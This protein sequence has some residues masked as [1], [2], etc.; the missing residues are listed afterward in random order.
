M[1]SNTYTPYADRQANLL[2]YEILHL[3]RRPARGDADPN[4]GV[5]AITAAGH[6]PNE[7]VSCHPGMSARRRNTSA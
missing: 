1:R 7:T 5:S 3:L 2:R 4:T 6:E